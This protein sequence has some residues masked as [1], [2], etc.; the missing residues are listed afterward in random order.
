MPITIA[1]R[2]LCKFIKEVE[3]F[4]VGHM[5]NS[6]ND[7]IVLR[8]LRIHR[9]TPEA[10]ISLPVSWCPSRLSW[11]KV[12]SDGASNGAPG[13]SGAGGIFRIFNGKSI[14]TF[15]VTLGIQFAFQVELQAVMRAVQIAVHFHFH[16]L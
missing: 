10:L 7:L 5:S 15:V 11:F 1:I 16:P 3:T 4:Q 8:K 6:Q 14:G 9:M 13:P 12:N 2:S